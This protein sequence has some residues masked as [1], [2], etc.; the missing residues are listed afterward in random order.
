MTAD[1]LPNNLGVWVAGTPLMSY[2]PVI[3]F[4]AGIREILQ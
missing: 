1:T 2:S 3:G 4:S